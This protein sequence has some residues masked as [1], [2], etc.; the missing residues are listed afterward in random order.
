MVIETARIVLASR[1]PARM[2]ILRSHGV[3]FE[4]IEAD[5]DDA[6]APPVGDPVEVTTALALS[7]ARAV[8]SAHAARCSGAFVLA[9]D[10]ICRHGESSIGKPESMDEA[11]H[12]LA[13][14]MD[15]A[16]RV[17]T[18]VAIVRDERTR[19][20]ADEALVRLEHPGSS[21]LE[22]YL[23]SGLWRGKAGAYDIAER[24][25]AGWVVHCE[26]DADTVGGMPWRRVAAH[27]RGWNA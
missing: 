4:S 24:R 25:A 10:T 11:A 2:A 17:V 23:H 19:T 26:G 15:G 21:A 5:V 16:H 7:K 8:R 20:F 1:S 9:A 22:T 27:L 18:G 6:S 13:C 12:I 3:S 14:M